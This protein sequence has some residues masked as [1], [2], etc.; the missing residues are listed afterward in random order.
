VRR[1]GLSDRSSVGRLRDLLRD[2]RMLPQLGLIK[3][4]SIEEDGIFCEV[5]LPAERNGAGDVVTIGCRLALTYCGASW[6]LVTEPEVGDE[7][8]VAVPRGDIAEGGV[9]IGR[10]PTE[11]DTLPSGVGSGRVLLVV[12]P[13]AELL[14]IGRAHV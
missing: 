11:E 13:G 9:I 4:L 12:K 10:M 3:S 5:E 14:K 1:A 7:V 8:V 6:G 2:R